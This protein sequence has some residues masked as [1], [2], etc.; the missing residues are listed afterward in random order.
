MEEITPPPMAPGRGGQGLA[1]AIEDDG[2]G[3]ARPTAPAKPAPVT[4]DAP[5]A[6]P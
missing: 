3:P 2:D 1:P 6:T 5:G 4:D